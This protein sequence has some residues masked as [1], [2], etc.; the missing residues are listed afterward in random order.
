M[1]LRRA[2]LHWYV[3]TML[4]T[5]Y[6]YFRKSCRKAHALISLGILGAY[7]WVLIERQLFVNLLNTAISSEVVAARVYTP[8][9]K[10]ARVVKISGYLTNA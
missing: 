7:A 6:S 10:G 3:N 4:F 8:D 9:R 5:M 1:E 2:C